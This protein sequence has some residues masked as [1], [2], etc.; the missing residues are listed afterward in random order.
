MAKIIKSDVESQVISSSYSLWLVALLGASLG[1]IFCLLTMIINQYFINPLFC[2]SS[3][4]ADICLNSVSVSGNIATILVAVIG[5]FTMLRLELDQPLLVSIV[6]AATLWGLAQLTDGL[7][8]I[9]IIAWSVSIY[10]LA[11]ILFSWIAR[12]R[13]ILSALV[14]MLLVIFIVRVVANF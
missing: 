8:A 4:N 7:S 10:A 1:L 13:R 12:Y 3:V 6:V 11:Y 9:E 2:G 5:I 14:V